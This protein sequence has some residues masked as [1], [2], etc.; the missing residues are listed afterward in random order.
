MEV[1]NENGVTYFERGNMLLQVIQSQ[2]NNENNEVIRRIYSSTRTK[3]SWETKLGADFLILVPDGKSREIL[4][5][6]NVIKHAVIDTS[7][8]HKRS[9]PGRYF[10][11]FVPTNLN[12]ESFDEYLNSSF[13]A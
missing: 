6:A 3:Y 1:G 7:E 9:Y 2:V 8:A 12:P 4:D 11:Q 10:Y 5:E 13:S